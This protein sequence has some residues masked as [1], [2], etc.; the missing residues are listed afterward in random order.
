MKSAKRKGVSQRIH[1][2]NAKLWIIFSLVISHNVFVLDSPKYI[3]YIW[4]KKI[5]N[6]GS[7]VMKGWR[8]ITLK[9]DGV[10]KKGGRKI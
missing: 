7:P 5:I 3:L 8:I 9:G 6:N 2:E 4:E 1:R 10:K